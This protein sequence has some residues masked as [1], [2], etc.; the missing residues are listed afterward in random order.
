MDNLITIKRWEK[1]CNELSKANNNYI[2]I[3]ILHFNEA[4]IDKFNFKQFENKNI[5]LLNPDIDFPPPKSPYLNDNNLNMKYKDRI[6]YKIIEFIE[7]Y[8]IT[9]ICFSSSIFH[10][11][12]K[13]I[14]LGVTWQTPLP[15][16]K[17]DVQNKNILC[18]ANFGLPTV[19]CW[20]GRIRQNVKNIISHINLITMDNVSKD[21]QERKTNN[22]YLSYFSNI[23][24]SKFSLCP[25]G[26]GIDCYRFYDCL[27]YDCIPIIVKSEDFYKN[28]SMFPILVLND[29]EDLKNLTETYLNN[30]YDELMKEK[31][32]Y[33]NYLN[34]NNYHLL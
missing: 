17:I 15:A 5:I 22:K 9:I 34:I 20:H 14:P 8:N 33:K 21:E 28:L 13:M 19:D 30:K 10:P 23:A 18:Y 7:R 2:L 26:C 31:T 6:H 11:N 24:R 12:V 29:W 27:I 3:N 32:G 16:L 4:N 25:R 1:Y